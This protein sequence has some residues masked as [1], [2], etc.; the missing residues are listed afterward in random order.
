MTLHFRDAQPADIPGM[1][2]LRARTRE[3]RIS[4]EDLAGLGIT[5]ESTA[6][7]MLSGRNRSWVCLDETSLAG[8]C[9]GD[10]CTGEVLVLAV[11]P[12]FEGR[13]I[14]KRLL[15]SVVDSLRSAGCARPW[16]AASPDPSLR[17]YGFYRWLKWQPTGQMTERGHE[18]LECAP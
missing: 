1:F 9:T 11:A 18:V 14:G 5:P 6:A 16:L 13:G 7:A 3:S 17:A 2:A 10:S 8:F 15:T 12:D 4:R